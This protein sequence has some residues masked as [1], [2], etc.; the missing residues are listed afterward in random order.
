MQCQSAVVDAA[1][2]DVIDRVRLRRSPAESL[3]A[4]P[5]EGVEIEPHAEVVNFETLE[6]THREVAPFPLSHAD[7]GIVDVHVVRAAV[8]LLRIGDEFGIRQNEPVV[9]AIVD[10]RHPEREAPLHAEFAL[11]GF[12]LETCPDVALA[13]VDPARAR[14]AEAKV[15]LAFVPRHVGPLQVVDRKRERA[16]ADTG[17][18]TR[19]IRRGGQDLECERRGL[20]AIA[21]VALVGNGLGLGPRRRSRDFRF[22]LGFRVR[23]RGRGVLAFR[24]RSRRRRLVLRVRDRRTNQKGGKDARRQ[25]A[26]SDVTG[27]HFHLRIEVRC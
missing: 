12:L 8:V 6:T 27:M 15:R 20:R 17:K 23:T 22:R 24:R 1:V 16:A 11:I 19:R 25:R 21:G 5:L 26:P 18:R 7:V 13:R 3:R 9:G 4:P 10:T 2:P 14:E